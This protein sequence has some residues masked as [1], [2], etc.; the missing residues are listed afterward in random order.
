MAV[1]QY[2]GSRYVPLFAD[3]IEWSA[4]NT[5][6]PL[7]IV[8]HEGNSYTSK[9]AVPKGIDIANEAFWALTGNYNA[10]VEL[11]RRETAAAKEL[12]TSAQTDID[13]LLPK[14]DFSTD[15]T[16]KKYVDDSVAQVA[17]VLPIQDFSAESTVKAY[18]DEGHTEVSNKIASAIQQFA[19]FEELNT[20]DLYA[21]VIY[22]LTKNGIFDPFYMSVVDESADNVLSFE[23][24][25]RVYKVQHVNGFYS[26]TALG[27]V[28]DN[29]TNN[30]P[31]MN[32]VV[33]AL[34]GNFKIKFLAGCYRFDEAVI[35]ASKV[36]L[37][38]TKSS[39]YPTI[40]GGSDMNT[41]FVQSNINAT[42]FAPYRNNQ[43]FIISLGDYNTGANYT[44]RFGSLL[45]NIVFT[46]V[47][48]LETYTNTSA[49]LYYCEH[50]I[51]MYK[52]CMFR[53]R[54]VSFLIINGG[55]ISLYGC[56]EH[57]WNT[58]E[59][60]F[61]INYQLGE[62]SAIDIYGGVGRTCALNISNVNFERTTTF[63]FMQVHEGANAHNINV[64]N[65]LT[66]SNT[67]NNDG[68]TYSTNNVN[69]T[70]TNTVGLFNVEE[71]AK[72]DININNISWDNAASFRASYGS[73]AKTIQSLFYANANCYINANIGSVI[74]RSQENTLYVYV[75]SSETYGYNK[76]IHIL[77]AQTD[78]ATPLCQIIGTLTD[79]YI[80][81]INMYKAA[82]PGSAL[83]PFPELFRKMRLDRHA[84]EIGSG[85]RH[86]EGG[87]DW[88]N[89]VNYPTGITNDFDGN[90]I[91]PTPSAICFGVMCSAVHDTLTVITPASSPD[92]EVVAKDTSAAIVATATKATSSAY[93]IYKV[94]NTS[95]NAF[96]RFEILATSKA[97]IL[98]IG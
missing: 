44:V 12:A 91:D 77:N 30:T 24:G 31:T 35:D 61:L 65:F 42:V 15:N 71:N 83:L 39:V 95:S 79:I 18:I 48:H 81:Y 82:S 1:T 29:R 26:A 96:G 21:D 6:E 94:S 56:W 75:G 78:S 47:K 8:L 55:C 13:T 19:T 52:N 72:F 67:I 84:S 5:Y 49:D 22:V 36:V 59:L 2:I 16:V 51:E 20:A 63:G 27:F 28:N 64:S 9:Q 88:G 60:R 54:N 97:R 66:E 43:R 10:Q 17:D 93:K 90:S 89:R 62:K 46:T 76:N 41:G 87:Y 3:P 57:D 68:Y 33:G 14:D 73:I 40:G 70:L 38:G 11:Y 50:A 85:F 58:I 98:Y 37:S 45:E 23:F 53:M 32:K 34:Q 74:V 86:F 4:S 25:A 92:I 80:P 69:A 7:T